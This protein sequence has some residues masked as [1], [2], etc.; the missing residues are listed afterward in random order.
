MSTLLWTP[1]LYSVKL[2]FNGGRQSSQKLLNANSSSSSS[3]HFRRTHRRFTISCNSSSSNDDDSTKPQSQSQSQ[4]IQLYS[5]IERSF[6]FL[7]P[8][9]MFHSIFL[10]LCF[11][12]CRL[13]TTSASQS[14]DAWWGSSSDWTQVEVIHFFHFIFLLAYQNTL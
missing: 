3:A 8:C 10:L 1:S 9:F 14:Q 13:V 6:L 5:Q 12:L 2:N 11:F 4:S 7:L